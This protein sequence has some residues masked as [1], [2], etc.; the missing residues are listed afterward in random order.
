MSQVRHV[1]WLDI[2]LSLGH[3]SVTMLDFYR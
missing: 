2:E 3:N 1:T